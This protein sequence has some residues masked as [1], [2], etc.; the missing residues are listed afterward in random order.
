MSGHATGQIASLVA[1]NIDGAIRSKGLTTAEVARHMRTDPK[2]VRRWR[3]GLVTPNQENM[4]R[5]ALLLVDGDVSAFYREQ[6]GAA[7]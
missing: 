2:A 7:A 3:K 5:L 4:Q 1:S 6:A